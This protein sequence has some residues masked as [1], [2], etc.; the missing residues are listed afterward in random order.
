MGNKS[1]PVQ[2]YIDTTVAI[3]DALTD[4]LHK[5]DIIQWKT[6]GGTAADEVEIKS[7]DGTI[8]FSSVTQNAN[9]VDRM[10]LNRDYKAGF[11]VPTIDSGVV[12]ITRCSG[13]IQ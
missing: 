9:F 13:R 8:I 6:T 4:I 2:I 5:G 11:Y 7:T 12:T 10:I 1:Q 3:A